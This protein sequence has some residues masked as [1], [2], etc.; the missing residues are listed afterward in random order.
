[1]RRVLFC[2][3]EEKIDKLSKS[4]DTMFRI[5]DARTVNLN[6]GLADKERERERSQERKKLDE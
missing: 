4:L 5:A 3:K 6:S 1:M 2:F